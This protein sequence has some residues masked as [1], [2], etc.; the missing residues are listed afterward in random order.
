MEQI[1]KQKA[2]SDVRRLLRLVHETFYSSGCQN[3]D[4][5]HIQMDHGEMNY[6]V[7]VFPL[8]VLLLF[9]SIFDYFRK[10]QNSS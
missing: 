6:G 1:E 10:R 3:A 8:D 7:T 2:G 9:L 5:W 4:S